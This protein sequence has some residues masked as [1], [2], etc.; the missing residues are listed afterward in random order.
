MSVCVLVP[1]PA[2]FC[3]CVCVFALFLQIC[4]TV[5]PFHQPI[6]DCSLLHHHK[7]LFVCL[8]ICFPCQS[9]SAVLLL[10]Q[11]APTNLTNEII[12]RF[13]LFVCLCISFPV[14]PVQLCFLCTSLHYWAHWN[15]HQAGPLCVHSHWLPLKWERLVNLEKYTFLTVD[16]IK[17]NKIFCVPTFWP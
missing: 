11:P 6:L 10:H 16:Q 2:R 7:S 13:C 4:S 1:S 15:H 17:I 3:L 12:T 14:R 5:L 8:Y 9:C